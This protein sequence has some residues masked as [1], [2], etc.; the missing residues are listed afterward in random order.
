MDEVVH[1]GKQSGETIALQLSRLSYLGLVKDK[2]NN[3]TEKD[4][5]LVSMLSVLA[6]V[7]TKTR[8]RPL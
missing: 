4:T 6:V 5:F 2:K 1:S 8:V 3:D 7:L